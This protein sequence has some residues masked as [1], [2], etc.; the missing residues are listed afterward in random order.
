MQRRTIGLLFVAL[1][2]GLFGKGLWIFAKAQLA[3]VLLARAWHQ[4]LSGEPSPKPWPWADTW[5]VA[6]LSVPRLHESHI[7]LAGASGRNMA[8]GPTH[9]DGT[10]ELGAD[11][12]AV[13]S[14]HR[15][16]HFAFLEQLAPGDELLL[17]TPD[18]RERLY[19]VETIDVVDE[20]DRWVVEPTQAATLTLVTCYPFDAIVPGGPGRYVV[21]AISA[22]AA[23]R[24]RRGHRRE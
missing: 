20:W 10:A 2:L 3:Q 14:G 11:S 12:N 5:P 1:S 6:E 15:D 4:R 17:T 16:T 21:R 19:R 8:F 23:R 13:L 22:G 18:A 9:L 7:V 24:T